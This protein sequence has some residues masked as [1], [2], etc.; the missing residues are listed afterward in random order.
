[1]SYIW[2]ALKRSEQERKHQT[3]T[4]QIMRHNFFLPRQQR[5]QRL[6]LIIVI[7]VVLVGLLLWIWRVSGRDTHSILPTTHK[8]PTPQ[9]SSVVPVVYQPTQSHR[10]ATVKKSISTSLKVS[11]L[12]PVLPDLSELPEA[13]QQAVKPLVFSS[14]LY[15][16]QSKLRSSVI[17]NN[18]SFHIGDF[19]HSELRIIDITEEG[20]ILDYHGQLFKVSVIQQLFN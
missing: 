6:A 15:N 20:I 14:H 5:Y 19:I 4:G 2:D 10:A 18:Q 8:L 11:T 12:V 13:V 9:L 7:L 3:F 16:S 17:V 1:M